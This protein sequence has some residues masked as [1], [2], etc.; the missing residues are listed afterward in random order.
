M[1]VRLRNTSAA[2]ETAKPEQGKDTTATHGATTMPG[3]SNSV[4][5]RLRRSAPAE[6]T[7]ASALGRPHA[8]L[9]AWARAGGLGLAT[10]GVAAAALTGCSSGTSGVAVG[11]ST[12]SAPPPSSAQSID[13]AP[14]D[15]ATASTATTDPSAAASSPTDIPSIAGQPGIDV[16]QAQMQL[17]LYAG[18]EADAIASAPRP[19]DNILG[20]LH[21]RIGTDS[22]NLNGDYGTLLNDLNLY[23][24][25]EEDRINSGKNIPPESASVQQVRGQRMTQNVQYWEAMY[26]QNP[27]QDNYAELAAAQN[28]VTTARNDNLIPKQQQDDPLPD[29]WYLPN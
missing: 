18:M 14:T 19:T 29:G 28:A 15:S 10:F 11:S 21:D 24:T 25:E 20:K 13:P 6:R 9:K 22:S 23:L 16:T 2:T 1:Q 7:E 17:D 4:L 26:R 12:P 8:T 3:G 5:A 27:T